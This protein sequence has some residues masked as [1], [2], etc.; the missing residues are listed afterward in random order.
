V[1]II[2]DKNLKDDVVTVI[3]KGD[4]LILIK[5]VL[6]VDIINIIS[7]YAPQVGLDEQ[8]KIEFWEQMD[9]LLREV[10]IDEK[11]YIGGDFNGHVGGDRVGYEMVHGGHGFGDRNASGESILEFAIAFD[12][13]LANTYYKKRDEH[14]ITFKSGTNKSQIDFF[15][16]RKVDRLTCKDCKV[17]PGESLTTQHRVLVL[18]IAIK[19]QSRGRKENNNPRTRW[20]NLKGENLE[21][22]KDKVRKE[23]VCNAEGDSNAMWNKMAESIRG[24]AKD[25]LGESKGRGPQTKETWWWDVEVQKT[26]KIKKTCFKVWQTDRNVENFERYKSARKEVKKAVRDA[27]SKAYDDFYKKLE[28]KEGERNIYKLAKFRD[29][30]TK[31]FNSVKCIKGEDSRVLVKEEEIKVRWKSYF[32]KLLNESHGDRVGTEELTETRDVT[33][34]RRINVSEVKN[35]LK[36]MS[37]GRALGPDGIPIEVWKHLG[38]EGVAW[39][40]KLFNKIMMSN[41]MPDEWRKSIL[42]PIYKNKGDI[43]SCSNY[44]GIKLMSHTMKLWERVIE[45]RLRMETTV[46]ENQFGFMPGRSTMEAIYLLRTLMEKYR[47]KKKDIYMAFIDLEKAYDRVP[48]DVIWWVL[49]KKGVTTRY[50]DV[51]RDMYEGAVTM[52]RTTAGEGSEFPITVGLHQGSALSPY[53]FAL[54]MD[55]L[56]R[57]IQ[58]GVPWCMLFADD[59]VLVDETKSGLN[60][61]LEVWRETLETKGF[62]ISRT[63]TEYMECNFS[64]RRSTSG[65]VVKLEGQELPKSA[66]FRYLGS[67]IHREGDITDDVTHRIKA[68]WLKWRSA[69][70]VLCDRRVPVKLKGKFYKTAV[71]PALLYGTECWATKKQ[72]VQ[73]MSVAEMR[74]LRWMCG[75]TRKDKIRNE[76]IRRLVEVAPIQDKLRENRLRWFGHVKRRPITAPVRKSELINIAGN[77]RGRGRPKLT[78]GE[79]VR[80]DMSACG[81]I[82]DI[83][84]DRSEWRNRIHVADPK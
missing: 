20:W 43:Q 8:T 54:I 60:A 34:F 80:Q 3:R 76:H 42:V 57:E 35:A 83:A 71:R 45:H 5:L 75:K 46:S 32:E 4:R 84:F 11:L 47:A 49:N 66:N 44:R 56:T 9:E 73:K 14:L 23:V 70:G 78:W 48:R 13:V 81:L 33:F 65:D 1:G 61:K 67:I 50:I 39:L 24:V 69:T 37:I 28:T 17:I 68:G 62:K 26:L 63:K 16:T 74:M 18:D 29:R 72:H 40:T 82:E 58:D 30:K 27:K 7:A 21:L 52:V 36:K 12:L 64:N 22:F 41:R 79:V 19:K 55:E 51:I 77:A 25:V 6:G 59:I 2:V 15:L 38:D 31:D 10:P 53:L